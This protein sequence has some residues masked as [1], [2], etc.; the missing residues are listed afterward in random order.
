MIDEMENRINERVGEYFYGYDDTSLMREL[1]KRL[2]EKELT[3]AV[4]ES[5]TGGL[6]Q[7]EMTAVVGV[8]TMLLGG[9]VC[10]SNQAK[11]NLCNVKEETL[12]VTGL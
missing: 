6:F 1:L 12:E 3:I 5:L 2:E 10:Y 4:A 11:V 7:S 8:S 9:I